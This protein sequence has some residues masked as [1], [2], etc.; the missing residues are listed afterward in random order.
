MEER[1]GV[2]CVGG[3]GCVGWMFVSENLDG[4]V[5][6]GSDCLGRCLRVGVIV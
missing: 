6:G 2:G 4:F 3:G 1:I 5:A